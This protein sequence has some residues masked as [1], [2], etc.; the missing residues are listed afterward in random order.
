MRSI[1]VCD[2]CTVAHPI[3]IGKTLHIKHLLCIV[4]TVF[5][6]V[7]FLRYRDGV[8]FTITNESTIADNY[9][10]AGYP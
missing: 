1:V 2:Y 5:I 9:V 3:Y 4:L 10:T 8:Q 7:P 6:Q